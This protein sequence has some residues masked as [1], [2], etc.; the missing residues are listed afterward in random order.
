MQ[1]RVSVQ[2]KSGHIFNSDKDCMPWSVFWV[3]RGRA[4]TTHGS[5]TGCTRT[6]PAHVSPATKKKIASPVT[7]VCLCVCVCVCAP[8][9]L[10]RDATVCPESDTLV[11]HAIGDLPQHHTVFVDTTHIRFFQ[12]LP[13]FFFLLFSPLSKLS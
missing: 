5:W 2:D 11:A 10:E 1:T 4:I 8:N 13:F 12:F 7:T 6:S 3:I 9:L